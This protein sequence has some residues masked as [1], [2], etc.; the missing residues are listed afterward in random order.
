MCDD[1]T[2]ISCMR[3]D[4]RCLRWMSSLVILDG[5]LDVIEVVVEEEDEDVI[6]R[7]SDD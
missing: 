6:Y 7:G 1:S 5:H 2:C 3:S 4:G